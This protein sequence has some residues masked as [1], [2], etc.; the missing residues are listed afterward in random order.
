M[1]TI[2]TTED[3][4]KHTYIW[5]QNT[6]HNSVLCKCKRTHYVTLS[7]SI[8]RYISYVKSGCRTYKIKA[9]FS[10]IHLNVGYCRHY[11]TTTAT[12]ITKDE[13]RKQTNKQT[14][15]SKT[16]REKSPAQIL[17]SLSLRVKSHVSVRMEEDKEWKIRELCVWV[18]KWMIIKAIKADLT[19]WCLN[20][21]PISCSSQFVGPI[22]FCSGVVVFL[23]IST[24]L[25][26]LNVS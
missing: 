3:T 11:K 8:D 17:F 22:F 21:L 4:D 9:H 16:Y 1:S 23:A 24:V 6:A 12:T 14:R 25:S 19:F 7:F 2:S 13:E 5:Y 15:I 18:R 26:N 10:W 20:F